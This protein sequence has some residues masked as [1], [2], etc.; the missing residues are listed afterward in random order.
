MMTNNTRFGNRIISFLLVV[1]MVLSITPI[2]PIKTSSAGIDASDPSAQYVGYGF[3]VTS[4]PLKKSTLSNT[5]SV[6]DLSSDI[7][8]HV[9]VFD[10]T[11]SEAYNTIGYSF[12]EVSE[13]TSSEFNIGIGGKIQMVTLDLGTSF[14]K[15]QTV[16]NAVQERYEVYIMTNVKKTVTIQLDATEIRDSYLSDSFKAEILSI[17][18]FDQAKSFLQKYGTHLITGYN[19]GGKLE[20]TNYQTKSSVSTSW[21]D[22]F[23]LKEQMGVAVANYGASQSFSMTQQY[24]QNYNTSTE[25]STYHCTL[26]GGKLVENLTVDHLFTYNASLMDGKG[27][28]VYGEWL[29]AL[30]KGESLEIIGISKG[31]QSIPM[32]ELI[33]K[34]TSSYEIRNFL[35]EAY[36]DMCGDKY[37]EYNNLYNKFYS[38]IAE[39]NS[40][41]EGRVDIDGYVRV[42]DDIV[43]EITL[44]D[45]QGSSEIAPNTTVYMTQ[46]L[47]CKSTEK[48]W[49]VSSGADYVTILDAHNGVFKLKEGVTSGKFIAQVLVNGEAVDQHTFTIKANKYTAGT[50]T[51]NDPYIIS[52]TTDIQKLAKNSDDWSKYFVVANDIDMSDAT[53]T[54]YWSMI[55]TNE[56]PFSGVFEGNY[57]TISNYKRN[58][59]GYENIGFFGVIGDNGNVLN[60]ILENVIIVANDTSEPKV[61]LFTQAGALVGKNSG[62]ITNCIVKNPKISITYVQKSQTGLNTTTDMA[63]IYVGAM[64]G[65]NNGKIEN[66]GVVDPYAHAEIDLSAFGH[67]G[68]EVYSYAGGMVGY[69][70]GG[71]YS[72]CYVK[73]VLTGSEPS[74]ISALATGEVENNASATTAK[75]YAGG[76]IGY[77]NATPTI[78]ECVI[79]I[80][81][82]VLA[83][84]RNCAGTADNQNVRTSEAYSGTLIGRAE[85]VPSMTNVF[86]KTIRQNQSPSTTDG[87]VRFAELKNGSGNGNIV[88]SSGKYKNLT[89]TQIVI[90]NANLSNSLSDGVWLG[91][92][93]SFPVLS[94]FVLSSK[95]TIEDAKTSYYYG[96][97]FNPNGMTVTIV[98]GN[99]EG[100][101]KTIKVYKIDT[102]NYDPTFAE[103]IEQTVTV[104][105][106]KI[107]GSVK[108]LVNKCEIIEIKGEDNTDESKKLWVDKE[109]SISERDVS[110]MAVLSNGERI[111]LLTDTTLPYVNYVRDGKIEFLT[112]T[113]ALVEGENAIV[114][115]YGTLQDTFVVTAEENKL[116]SIEIIELSPK[117][118][119]DVGD[120]FSSDGLVVEATYENGETEIVNNSE[121]ELIGTEISEGLNYVVVSYGPYVT[122]ERPVSVYGVKT[123]LEVVTQ[124]TKTQY[125]VGETIDLN[126]LKIEA[127]TS[128]GKTELDLSQCTISQNVI[129]NIGDNVITITYRGVNVNVVLVGKE[130]IPTLEIT[131]QP[132]KVNYYQGENLDLSGMSLKYTK[133]TYEKTVLPSECQVSKTVL[134]EIGQTVI[135]LTYEAC[136]VSF[137]VNIEQEPST[138]INKADT[139]GDGKTGYEDAV[140]ILQFIHFP[141]V[142]SIEYGTGDVN[143]DGKITVDDAI[144][145]KNHLTD[146]TQYPID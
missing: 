29:D 16:E 128:Q 44:E 10:V 135:T 57:C 28:F 141:N 94:T 75:T 130:A 2:F 143:G 109:Y 76:M 5:K 104:T 87:V 4:G 88:E 36:V 90:T 35:V 125:F 102:S 6:L 138:K 145:L 34:G 92:S 136:T 3:D 99:G 115:K 48:T 103:A 108:A 133:G 31:G 58:G 116:I 53:D 100:E 37:N 30:N 71:T 43:T 101:T 121:L 60:L 23:S 127:T 27:G 77:S 65:Y 55:G 14:D 144:Y 134:T 33:P 12:A 49:T 17:K 25:N 32:W 40:A 79:D 112:K 98:D 54:E 110:V 140:A 113:Q 84:R 13:K 56:K 114:V 126:G 24:S 63:K 107:S 8:D 68:T 111:N 59:A 64:F 69:A 89:D 45:G 52:K 78:T 38:N 142:Y 18:N 93:N 105:V 15:S 91:D 123:Q 117:T 39:E 19:L 61:N 106:G 62:T 47:G 41:S 124:P 81:D 120:I 137:V 11:E 97:A 46:T 146:P 51:Q 26:T 7:Y 82:V 119:Y 131:T 86:A 72:K 139:T 132:V 74:K 20:V 21:N 83:Q 1:I 67:I 85:N 73:T 118:E 80:P 22:S 70:D 96:E 129:T 66:C 50:G 95:A 42:T 122:T 9:V